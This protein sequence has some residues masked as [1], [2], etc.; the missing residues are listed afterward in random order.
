MA[1]EQH[2]I[3][4]RTANMQA[5]KSCKRNITKSTIV[6]NSVSVGQQTDLVK[7]QRQGAESSATHDASFDELRSAIE[8]VLQPN[9]NSL[10]LKGLTLINLIIC[11][12]SEKQTN[13]FTFCAL[14]IESRA[15]ELI[16]RILLLREGEFGAEIP[17]SDVSICSETDQ[18]PQTLLMSAKI[19]CLGI[20]INLSFSQESQLKALFRKG[21][22]D[23]LTR[24][25]STM[26]SMQV[27]KKTIQ[28][29]A[30]LVSGQS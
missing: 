11:D 24:M 14:L 2:G 7:D 5:Y 17:I 28:A 20:L 16:L 15:I 18:E 25:L 9:D 3:K 27:Y 29:L 8:M 10:C 23:V 6:Q 19:E 13:F 22:T 21:C 4:L 12:H 26:D 1:N 30:N